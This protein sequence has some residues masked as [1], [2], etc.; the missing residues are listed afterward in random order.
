ME[1]RRP[2]TTLFSLSL[3][4]LQV[5][6]TLTGLLWIE[7]LMTV[8]GLNKYNNNRFS[9]PE[10]GSDVQT[11]AMRLKLNCLKRFTWTGFF[12]KNTN[13]S[14]GTTPRDIFSNFHFRSSKGQSRC[15]LLLFYRCNSTTNTSALICVSSK[16]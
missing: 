15:F 12:D 1:S 2:V 5:L 8:T 16:N 4:I 14:L 10:C 11:Q 13:K 9:L 3:I 7:S 6:M